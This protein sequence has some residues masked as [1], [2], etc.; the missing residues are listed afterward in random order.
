M[1]L[2]EQTK[3]QNYFPRIHNIML[4]SNNDKINNTINQYS[5][6]NFKR[7]CIP[8]Y[9]FIFFI[10][11]TLFSNYMESI[12]QVLQLHKF[13]SSIVDYLVHSNQL[14][15]YILFHPPL[16]WFSGFPFTF[17]IHFHQLYNIFVFY[18]NRN[19]M[20]HNISIIS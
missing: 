14:S 3:V 8:Y 13:R 17:Y 1:L 19:C 7:N 10:T 9:F 5:T 15:S 6:E 16:L 11:L 12:A 4:L 20:L 18:N 2:F